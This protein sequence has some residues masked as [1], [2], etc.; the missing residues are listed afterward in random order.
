MTTKEAAPP[1]RYVRIGREEIPTKV[2]FDV[3]KRHAG[4]MI[5]VAYGGFSRH[6]H[7][8]GAPFK[9]VIDKSIA[10]TKYFRLSTCSPGG[11]Q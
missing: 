7:D 1:V 11:A 9:R 5:E 6:E 10:E 8:D 3:P 2:R 4:Q